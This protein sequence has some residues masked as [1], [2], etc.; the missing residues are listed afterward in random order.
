MF[1]RLHLESLERLAALLPAEFPMPDAIPAS[2]ADDVEDSDCDE[3]EADSGD[4]GGVSDS[5]IAWDN[6]ELVPIPAGYS[7]APTSTAF[8]TVIFFLLWCRVGKGRAMWHFGEVKKAY[9]DGYTHRRAPYTHDAVMDH[10]KTD[11]GKPRGVNLTAAQKADGYW[12]HLVKDAA[13]VA[14]VLAAPRSPTPKPPTP[15][16][17]NPRAATHV[18]FRAVE[19][20]NNLLGCVLYS[21]VQLNTFIGNMYLDLQ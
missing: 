4:D 6:P 11:N 3:M 5:S 10:G 20:Q 14:I 19:E 16:R 2:H 15:P 12:V 8:H 18:V 7:R 13:A 21:F 9:P 1:L 17:R